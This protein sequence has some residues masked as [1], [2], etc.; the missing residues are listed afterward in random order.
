MLE[1]LEYLPPHFKSLTFH[2]NNK[3]LGMPPWSSHLTKIENFPQNES[4]RLYRSC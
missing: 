1:N 3:N 2:F 4:K